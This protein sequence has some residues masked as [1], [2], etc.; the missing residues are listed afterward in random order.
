MPADAAYVL[1]RLGAA[2]S[3]IAHESLERIQIQPVAM[4]H[5]LS[6]VAEAGSGCRIYRE[7]SGC[8]VVSKDGQ[9]QQGSRL[10]GF[11]QIVRRVATLATAYAVCQAFRGASGASEASP[12]PDL[13]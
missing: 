12:L 11:P 3:G 6:C 5:D 9:P 4:A 8:Y 10:S 2:M 13:R 7:T 1:C